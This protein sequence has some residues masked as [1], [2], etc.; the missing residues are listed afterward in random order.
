MLT[1]LFTACVAP[2]LEARAIGHLGKEKFGVLSSGEPIMSL[3][4]GLLLLGEV[5]GW[6]VAAGV[7]IIV[8][9]I[10]ANTAELD[11]PLLRYLGRLE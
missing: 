4:V 7:L 1:G 9:A 10:V 3:P 5:P 11:R 8:V 6:F 2:V